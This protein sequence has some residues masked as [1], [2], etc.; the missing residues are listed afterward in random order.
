MITFAELLDRLKSEDE[1]T[2][3]EMLD[4]TSEE[5]VPLLEFKIHEQ[6]EKFRQ[7]YSETD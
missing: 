4:L 1:L 2:L 3:L 6:Q 5:L 7:L